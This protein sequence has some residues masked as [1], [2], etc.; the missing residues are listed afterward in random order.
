MFFINTLKGNESQFFLNV[1]AIRDVIYFM[2]YPKNTTTV[3]RSL[4]N[5]FYTII[6]KVFQSLQTNWIHIS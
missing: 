5:L 1:K 3:K 2:L 4:Q 6:A